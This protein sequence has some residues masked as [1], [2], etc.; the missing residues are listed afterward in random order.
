M[1]QIA[2][3]LLIF[4]FVRVLLVNGSIQDRGD[5]PTENARTEIREEV[6]GLCNELEEERFSQNRTLFKLKALPVEIWKN[7]ENVSSLWSVGLFSSS[8]FASSDAQLLDLLTPQWIEQEFEKE[9]KKKKPE[10]KKIVIPQKALQVNALVAVDKALDSMVAN[11]SQFVIEF[12]PLVNHILGSLGIEIRISDILAEN[13][14]RSFGLVQPLDE[15]HGLAQVYRPSEAFLWEVQKKEHN[16][17][18][19]LMLSGLDICDRTG[20]V[21]QPFRCSL[22]GVAG[23]SV[24]A[25][26][27]FR[28]HNCAYRTAII[29]VPKPKDRLPRWSSAIVAAHEVVHLI[30]RTNHDGEED[31]LGGGPGNGGCKGFSQHIMS[32]G[33]DMTD[34]FRMCEN[35]EPWSKCTIQ[36]VEFYT[37]NWTKF[38]PGSF[39][40][41]HENPLYGLLTLPLAAALALLYYCYKKKTP[42][43]IKLLED[44]TERLE[45]EALLQSGPL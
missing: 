7:Q 43:V 29:E 4:A 30:G 18:V 23:P 27:F 31:Y 41:H 24:T 13:S 5:E 25:W 6:R 9:R 37:A 2:P 8:F 36:Q 44:E 11:S 16:H 34:L 35:Y 26:P 19:V 20:R 38:C 12:F 28:R 15:G 21:D 17:D 14:E 1:G 10:K 33:R 22:L 45:A 42:L 32:P 40:T 3:A 39:F